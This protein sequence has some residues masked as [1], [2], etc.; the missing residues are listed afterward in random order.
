MRAFL[1][2]VLV[3]SGVSGAAF[4]S[5][6]ISVS[7]A[8]SGLLVAI[9]AQRKSSKQYWIYFVVFLIQVLFVLLVYWG[10]IA[11]YGVPY[12]KGGSDDFA[13]ENV[14]RA[15]LKEG[16]YFLHQI[17]SQDVYLASN[18]QATFLNSRGFIVYLIWLQRFCDCLGGYHTLVPRF[19][20]MGLW[21]STALLAEKVYAC[22]EA[23][24]AR[25]PSWW[26]VPALGLFPNAM[27]IS[28][29]VFRDTLSIW[30]IVFSFY[31]SLQVFNS[32]NSIGVRAMLLGGVFSL[33]LV[34]YFIRS[35]NALYILSVG[36]ICAL[37]AM[38]NKRA[39]IFKSRRWFAISVV[40]ILVLFGII[41]QLGYF[42]NIFRK[43]ST[44]G[45]Y[46]EVRSEGLSSFVFGRQLLPW[47]V[48]LRLA[49]ALINPVPVTLLSPNG[50]FMSINSVVATVVSLGSVIQLFGYPYLLRSR[51]LKETML[52]YWVFLLSVSIVTF[53]FRHFILTYPVY[54][55]LVYDGLNNTSKSKRIYYTVY[56]A[57]IALLLVL[58]YFMAKRHLP[59]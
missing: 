46:R 24:G 40:M 18:K 42:G 35:E 58:S 23:E 47:G 5:V 10:D 21:L 12:Y 2:A 59:V 43:V 51:G 49:Y 39:G 38:Y 9:T 44:L 26:F 57:I 30:M 16:K 20:N 15:L 32:S 36:G 11:A 54:W 52:V 53:T 28:A 29:Y 13:F 27:H 41:Y 48:F 4:A 31:L 25:T 55:L 37:S 6:P 8:V 7:I 33:S 3:L 50:W 56:M 34:S 19:L 45:T 22:R 17:T 1:A 14:S